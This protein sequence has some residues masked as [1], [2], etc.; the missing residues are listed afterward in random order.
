MAKQCVTISLLH[1]PVAAVRPALSFSLHSVAAVRPSELTLF[2]FLSLAHGRYALIGRCLFHM[3]PVRLLVRF[4]FPCHVTFYDICMSHGEPPRL[5]LCHDYVFS[6][7]PFYSSSVMATRL[8]RFSIRPI[9]Y[10]TSYPYPIGRY[11]CLLL[12]R[13]L[14]QFVLVSPVLVYIPGWRW[15]DP[16]LQSTLQPP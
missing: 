14:C 6:L 5:F 8:S 10:P 11:S 9:L 2:L 12:L 16:H 4:P 1:V 13:L 7:M 15:D 3:P